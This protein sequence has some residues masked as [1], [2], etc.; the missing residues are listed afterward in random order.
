MSSRPMSGVRE[1]LSALMGGVQSVVDDLSGETE[2]LRQQIAQGK[3]AMQADVA[4]AE[5]VKPI[6]PE[7]E[8][9][10]V[11]YQL[12]KAK[13]AKLEKEPDLRPALAA[14]GELG[15]AAGNL[16][17]LGGRHDVQSKAMADCAEWAQKNG[18]ALK[19]SLENKEIGTKPQPVQAAHAKLK[20]ADRLVRESLKSDFVEARTRY[21]TLKRQLDEFQKTI[22]GERTGKK[23]GELEEG[24]NPA[25]NKLE[26][27]HPT[28]WARMRELHGEAE[29]QSE[30]S[31][32]QD[33]AEF[34]PLPGTKTPPKA[35]IDPKTTDMHRF[36][37]SPYEA[38]LAA[39]MP[40]VNKAAQEGSA[41]VTNHQELLKVAAAR[42]KVNDVPGA[43]AALKQIELSLDN[44]TPKT[45]GGNVEVG[46]VFKARLTA[47]GL[48]IERAQNAKHSAAQGAKVKADEAG[49]LAGKRDAGK[50][51]FEHAHALL[52]EC[53][54]LL[55]GSGKPEFDEVHVLNKG[56]AAGAEA[57][58][59]IERKATEK[60]RKDLTDNLNKRTGKAKKGVENNCKMAT[61][62]A[63]LLKA[64]P[65]MLNEGG[66]FS[67]IV[68]GTEAQIEGQGQHKID[69]KKPDAQVVI[70]TITESAGRLAQGKG[71][72]NDANNVLQFIGCFVDGLTEVN[73]GKKD[74]KE[75][76]EK[77]WPSFRDSFK[78]EDKDKK[79]LLD[80]VLGYKEVAGAASDT[81]S[82][83]GTRKDN[84]RAGKMPND[85][86]LKIE[87]DNALIKGDISGSMHS[88]LLAQELSE[89]LMGGEGIK[90]MGDPVLVKDKVLINARA[91]D[92]LAITAGGKKGETDT[93]FHTAYEMINGMRAISGAPQV[94][95]P[96]A[97]EIMDRMM[98]GTSFTDAMESIFKGEKLPW[99]A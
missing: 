47:L 78:L 18:A 40:H 59:G 84:T 6:L 60:M 75:Q 1:V 50:R 51:D 90:S 22:Y 73:E 33:E 46:T 56:W 68:G 29:P 16:A 24:W 2:R 57:R 32:L 77:V 27:H 55:R 62:L 83:K 74:A 63:G 91:L 82:G 19:V 41:D 36:I 25:T 81:L 87:D 58:L 10:I 53:E 9:P 54:E 94:S 34:P 70:K 93:V 31:W 69:K 95:Q 4:R 43:I 15:T 98:K 7:F 52:D 92:A 88:C 3:S 13:L 14:V 61:G 64:N 26:H 79:K 96:I 97:T 37:A 72:G 11:D 85:P 45:D 17:A 21:A 80:R 44:P 42:A 38:R 8:K 48:R 99:Q 65:E 86:R 20:E 30:Q 5:G 89:S 49:V 12:A 39:L 76:F 71:E 66:L 28:E 35:P 23:Q 67:R